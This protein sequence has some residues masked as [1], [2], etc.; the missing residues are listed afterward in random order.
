MVG[1][2][3]GLVH[4]PVM[5]AQRARAVD[6]EWG[7]ETRGEVG[8]CDLFGEQPIILVGEVIHV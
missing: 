7:A 4:D 8:D 2:G 3:K 1:A 6:V 5:T